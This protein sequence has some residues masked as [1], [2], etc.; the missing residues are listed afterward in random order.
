MS[1][2]AKL[3]LGLAAAFVTAVA[4]LVVALINRHAMKEAGARAQAHNTEL[5]RLKAA[6]QAT[7]AQQDAYSAYVYDAR[8]RLYAEFQPLLFQLVE[9]CESAY[10]RVRARRKVR[11][12]SG[13]R[14]RVA[15]RGLPPEDKA[16]AV[17]I[18]P[19]S[20]A[21]SPSPGPDVRRG[22]GVTVD[23]LDAISHEE[24][25][26]FDWREAGSGISAADAFDVPFE[27]I[28]NY[29]QRRPATAPGSEL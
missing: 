5:E 14:R 6:L 22:T 29:L 25:Q 21:P 19:S 26:E 27:A 12:R 17:A 2:E 24:R 4:S 8:R 28:R 1:D 13:G 3:A 23:P 18:A 10:N 16:G 11:P 9:A 7:Q 15:L 20:S